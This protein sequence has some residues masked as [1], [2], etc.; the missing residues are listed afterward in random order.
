MESTA[1]LEDQVALVTGAGSP[2][3][4]GIACARLLARD[5]A[6]VA[7]ASTT[8]RIHEREAELGASGAREV[9]ALCADLTDAAAASALVDAV[10][11]RFGR[12]DVLVN[13]A[14]I[15]PLGRPRVRKSFAEMDEA[16]W[17]LT[18]ATNLKT[19]FN[20]TKAALPHMLERGYGRIVNVS[21]VTGPLV[22]SIGSAG[23]SAAKSGLE[24][25]MRA[26]ALE[27]AP[28]GITVNSVLPGWIAT[29][30]LSQRQLE[31][32][33]Y[34]AIGRA[35]RPEEVAEAVAFFASPGAS[36]VTGQSIVVDGGNIIQEYKGPGRDIPAG[37]PPV[38]R[39]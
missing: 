5:G 28:N 30:A 22:S 13:N 17:D 15:G 26:L 1:R 9:L 20:T 31:A 33:R 24:G 10:I 18:I 19:A 8:E 34:S 11:A 12:L 16:H 32:G 39:S 29:S 27:V 3:G 36:Y 38:V 7:I 25:M 21:S 2:T 4:I 6:R 14:G 35:G 23:Y 37:H